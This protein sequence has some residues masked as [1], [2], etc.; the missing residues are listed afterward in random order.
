MMPNAESL[1]EDFNGFMG[2]LSCR[3]DRKYTRR[4]FTGQ[5]A[6]TVDNA[7]PAWGYN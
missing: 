4:T 5:S 6:V 2:D 3:W 1:T 7:D